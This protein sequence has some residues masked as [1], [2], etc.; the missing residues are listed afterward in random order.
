[1]LC[2]FKYTHLVFV[3]TW[4]MSRV[5]TFQIYFANFLFKCNTRTDVN[6][7]VFDIWITGRDWSSY[8]TEFCEY[9]CSLWPKQ[10]KRS[11]LY[12]SEWN[13]PDHL[14]CCGI[15]IFDWGDLWELVGFTCL[16]VHYWYFILLAV[17]CKH[18][19]KIQTGDWIAEAM[20]Q[21]FIHR[22]A[23]SVRTITCCIT[24]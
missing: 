16:S 8:W 4:K 9:I 15:R 18:S 13:C 21:W 20:V 7:T 24:R 22:I 6:N 14:W 11:K 3:I 12:C 23:G 17:T 1:M 5:S 2:H 19:L 10:T